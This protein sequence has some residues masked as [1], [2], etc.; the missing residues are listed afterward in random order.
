MREKIEN[1]LSLFQIL[2][3]KYTVNY[4]QREYR[5]G[6]KQIEQLIDDLAN[7]F[8]DSFSS[9][10]PVELIDI[11][12]TEKPFEYYYM[13][14]V[15]VTSESGKESIIDGQQRLT[16][17]TL[18][19]IA[20]K[21]LHKEFDSN[22]GIDGN[23]QQLI[24]SSR[25]GKDSFNLEVPEWQECLKALND[26]RTF[27]AS[28][29]SESVQTI[30]ARYNDIVDLL[31]D[32]FD[33][34]KKGD[35]ISFFTGWVMYKTLFIKIVT[36]NEQDANK[37][38]VSMNDRGLSL[39][40]SE[41]LK[42]YLLSEIKDNDERN[43]ANQ[44]WKDMVLKIKESSASDNDGVFNTEDVNFLSLWIRAKYAMTIREGKKD[45]KDK[46]YEIIGREFHEWVRNNH[47]SLGLVN[48][49]DFRDFIKVKFVKYAD[50]YL[51][52]KKYS[53][54]Y[55][56]GYEDVF[57][58]ADKDLNYQAMFIISAISCNDDEETTNRK[59][60]LVAKYIDIYSTKRLVNFSKINWNTNKADL[61]STIKEIRDKDI[62]TIAVVLTSKLQKMDQKLS[63]IVNNDFSWNQFTGKYILHL[64]ARFTDFINVS[65]GSTS[66][67]P[68]YVN[69]KVKNSYDR[70]H[71]LCDHYDWYKDEFSSNEEFNTFRYKL[72]DLLLLTLDKN[73]SYNDMPYGD[74]VTYYI[75]NNIIA[76]SFC[77]KTY[78][79]NPKFLALIKEK[80]YPFHS[81][82]S[83]GKNEINERQELYQSLANDIWD[84][85][86]LRNVAGSWNEELSQKL[87]QAKKEVGSVDLLK[88]SM[89]ELTNKKVKGFEIEKNTIVSDS[90]VSLTLNLVDY[91]YFKDK[92][93][94]ERLAK[95]KF[96]NR[97]IT[98]EANAQ[99]INSSDKYQ[100]IKST[101]TIEVQIHGS[102]RDLGQFCK[103]L[104]SEFAVDSFEV[105]FN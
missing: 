56:E 84:E 58:N 75:S 11:D 22:L 38:F 18:L 82:E 62:G 68:S 44:T 64:L 69:R 87:I 74:K 10:R 25:L 53:D 28:K 91:L 41:M 80:N 60:K 54:T 93:T 61:F 85:G 50:I 8:E 3:S 48:S 100:P 31:N 20:L 97:L 35:M 6:K 14:T 73:R 27:D 81:Y 55:T 30:F 45:A 104:L 40:S 92:E 72:G 99:K 21:N 90:F 2:Q 67:F 70:E 5:W 43:S 34:E 98:K 49:D 65:I 12:S 23:V 83:F 26:G 102:N 59:I 89:D 95:A 66:E 19:L 17:L 7:V 96:K 13:G 63:S 32:R 36:K 52:I 47:K 39:N 94:M 77:E 37:I 1:S 79:R 105:F 33:G 16:S 86:K 29:C 24:C 51:R 57:Y 78:D 46:D 88:C 103:D 101:D 42:G 15:I 76:Q 4:Y 71:V 9:C